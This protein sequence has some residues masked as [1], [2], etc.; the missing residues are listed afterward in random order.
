AGLPVIGLDGDRGAGWLGR[1]R[2]LVRREGIDLIHSHLPYAAVGA[3]VAFTRN[4]V[5]RVYTEHAA[6][7]LYHRATY[8]AN[9]L[10]FHRADHVF[11]VSEHV[12]RSIRYPLPLRFLPMPPVETLYHGIDPAS[13]PECSTGDGVRRELGIDDTAPLVGTVSNFG[14]MKGQEYLLAALRLVRRSFPD[15]RAVLV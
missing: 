6:W 9:L 2:A 7:D 15:L 8:W 14:P 13:V 10:T 4:E 5:K 11:A 1:L 12:R 3:R